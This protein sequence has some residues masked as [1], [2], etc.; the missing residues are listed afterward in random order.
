[1][2]RKNN[3]PCSYPTVQKYSNKR[4]LRGWPARIVVYHPDDTVTPTP[5]PEQS[6]LY[7]ASGRRVAPSEEGRRSLMEVLTINQHGQHGEKGG[8]MRPS[9]L[10]LAIA[11]GWS[12]GCTDESSAVSQRRYSEEGKMREWLSHGLTAVPPV[13]GQPGNQL[14]PSPAVPPPQRR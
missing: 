6:A 9:T 3:A 13:Y 4:H 1:M 5:S 8:D 10:L 12:P 14:R 2:T 7:S 11:L